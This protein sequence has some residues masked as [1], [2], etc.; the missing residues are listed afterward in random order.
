L[1]NSPRRRRDHDA[2]ATWT[3]GTPTNLIDGQ[4]YTSGAASNI[5]RTYDV[6]PDGKRFLMIKQGGGSD[7]T[8]APTSIVVVQLV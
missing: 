1:D 4:Y 7:Q 3:A 2:G 8:P 5:A 6:S